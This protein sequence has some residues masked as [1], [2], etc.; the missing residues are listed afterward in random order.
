MPAAPLTAVLEGG[1]AAVFQ[2]LMNSVIFEI[3]EPDMGASWR[4]MIVAARK[5]MEAEELP[6]PTCRDQE[7]WDLE[8]QELSDSILW[9]ADYESGDL[10]LDRPPEEA[11]E[12]RREMGVSEDYFAGVADDLT[13]EQTKAKAAELR[14]LCAAVVGQ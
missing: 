1:I 12:L 8:I 6:E 3:D 7:E 4:E 14:E 9:D 2:H 13:E 10:Y 11:R 5:E